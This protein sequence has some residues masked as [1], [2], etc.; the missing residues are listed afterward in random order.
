M[1][2][3]L[4]ALIAVTAAATPQQPRD[5]PVFSAGVSL[6]H[7]DAEALTQDGRIIGGLKKDD[8]RVLDEG[9]KQA[10]VHFA[11]EEES[12]DLILLFDISGSMLPKVARV[13]EAA[14]RGFDQLRPGDRVS[15]MVFNS[16]SRVVCPFTEDFNKVDRTIREIVTGMRFGGGTRIQAAADDAALLLMKE[17][18]TER[19]RAVL[20][21]TDNMGMRTRSEQAVVRDFWEADAILS[22]LII[23]DRAMTTVTWATS[24]AW[25]LLMSAGMKGIAAKTGGDAVSVDDPGPAFQQAIRRIRARYSLYYEQPQAKPGTRRTLRVELEPEADTR[26]P[27]AQVRARTGYVVPPAAGAAI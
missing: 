15:V 11:A 9:K 21:V 5:T 22:G 27:K 10:I 2:P 20:I 25:M 12:L 19:R 18:R 26:Y 23:S 8:F 7:V 16:R 1:I 3:L 17:P 13:A 4:A 14:R 6:V 24:P